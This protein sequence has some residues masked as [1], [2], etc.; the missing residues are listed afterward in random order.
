MVN[1]R[2]SLFQIFTCVLLLSSLA[3]A[4]TIRIQLK[5]EE[6][7][8]FQHL[9]HRQIT[10]KLEAFLKG[11]SDGFLEIENGHFAFKQ[12]EALGRIRIEKNGETITMS[13]TAPVKD[14][15]NFIMNNRKK[16]EFSVCQSNLKSMGIAQRMYFI[17]FS[18]KFPNKISSLVPNYLQSIPRCP[19]KGAP[20]YTY[21]KN[22]VDGIHNYEFSCQA[23]HSYDGITEGFPKFNGFDGLVPD[24]TFPIFKFHL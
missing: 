3:G 18:G 9:N 17:D 19:V 21:R 4:Q 10:D 22:V 15:H 1:L 24:S 13:R 6:S 16:G 2:S 7:H 23:D 11:S 8:L 5:G 14:V 20:A 12:E